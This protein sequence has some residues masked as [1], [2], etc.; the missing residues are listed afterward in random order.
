MK[1][2]I[3]FLLSFFVLAC[4]SPCFAQIV[5]GRGIEIRIQGVPPEEKGRIDGNY[6]VSGAGTVRMP[7]IGPQG[8]SAEVSIAGLSTNAAAAKL[9]AL[10]KDAG[11][12][13]SPTF[14]ITDSQTGGTVRQDMVTISGFVRAP[15]PKPYTPGLTI[16]QAIA[17][18]GGATEFGSIKRVLLMR[19]KSNR[20]YDMNNLQDRAIVLLPEDTVDIPEKGVFER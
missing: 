11:I 2:R 15:G 14:Q 12:Y 1:H 20:V 10:Y 8:S 5:A 9:E 4:F 17:A 19:G 18:A 16:F 3:V 6:S 7:L 13:S